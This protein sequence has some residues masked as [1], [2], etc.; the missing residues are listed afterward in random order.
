MTLV[1]EFVGS[2]E[3]LGAT[4][5]PVS[6]AFEKST[7]P[8]TADQKGEILLGQLITSVGA[9]ITAT[10]KELTNNQWERM[11][12][13]CYGQ[14]LTPAGGTEL[15]GMGSDAIGRNLFNFSRELL[16]QPVGAVN[17][18]RNLTFFKTCPDP[19]SVNYGGTEISTMPVTFNVFLD[20]DIDT[21][22]DLFA[23]GNSAQ[24]VQVA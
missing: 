9:T 2:V 7:L 6:I 10:L 22:V 16:L 15:V 17:N 14:T 5:G 3:G 19:E 4:D 11:V 24:D 12:G 13:T 20:S 21:K 18:L 8:I 1:T 23:F